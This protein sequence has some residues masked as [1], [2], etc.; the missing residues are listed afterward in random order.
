MERIRMYLNRR[1]YDIF[2]RDVPKWKKQ[3]HRLRKHN[4]HV[5]RIIVWL[6]KIV[7]KGGEK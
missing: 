4:G 7:E 6:R 5:N 3:T 1:Y 2:W